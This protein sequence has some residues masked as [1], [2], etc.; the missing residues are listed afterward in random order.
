[1]DSHNLK[2]MCEVVIKN[3]I[4]FVCVFGERVTLI[5]FFFPEIS[6][7]YLT[8]EVVFETSWVFVFVCWFVLFFVLILNPCVWIMS[9]EIGN[10]QTT[11]EILV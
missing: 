7:C 5:F 11:M 10:K 3:I 2:Y 4:D 1:M 9:W 8:E 6:S